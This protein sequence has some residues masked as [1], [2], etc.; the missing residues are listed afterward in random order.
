MKNTTVH[1]F[2]FRV[3]QLISILVLWELIALS[4]NIPYFPKVEQIAS[5]LFENIFS[6]SFL[7]LVLITLKDFIIGLALAFALMVPFG[8]MLASFKKLNYIF[9]PFIEF[10]RPLPSSAIIPIA[11]LFL[12][13]DSSMKIFVIFFGS[14]WPLLINTRDGVL[15]LDK[16]NIETAVNFAL[17]KRI[18]FSK[19]Y[20]PACL[21]YIFS[22]LKIS[23][24]IALILSITV[25]MI[26]GGQGLGSYIIDM[27]R[28]FRFSEMYSGVIVI[29][30]LGFLI[31][32]MTILVENKMWW[33][34]MED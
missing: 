7:I 12:G 22:G 18:I 26:V 32:K 29:G 15:A 33:K 27:E 5:S 13:I 9:T 34:M 24:A 14:S 16:I 20:I 17:P 30:M 10:L 2:L 1:A 11:I 19:I 3:L 23:T 21:P 8:L 6:S 4:L 28:S 25:E 31:N